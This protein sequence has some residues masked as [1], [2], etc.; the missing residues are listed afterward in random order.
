MSR[1]FATLVLCA[2]LACLAIAGSGRCADETQAKVEAPQK[3]TRGWVCPYYAYA[4][5]PGYCA[6]YAQECGGQYVSINLPCNHGPGNCGSPATNCVWVGARDR[7]DAS[8]ADAPQRKPEVKLTSKVN[9]ADELELLPGTS[10]YR[11]HPYRV[12]YR[13]KSGDI[14]EVPVRISQVKIRDASPTKKIWVFPAC[15]VKAV[16]PTDPAIEPDKVWRID[17]NE[18]EA[19][20]MLEGSTRRVHVVTYTRL[21]E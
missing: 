8:R 21:E 3:S 6:W 15:E 16:E 7:S 13:N 1:L 11:S 9:F 18:L 2:L 20:V 19:E 17:E 5:Y 12:R 10:L 14:V 4:F